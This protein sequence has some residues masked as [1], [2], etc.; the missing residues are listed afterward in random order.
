MIYFVLYLFIETV[1]SVSIAS[2]I[3]P[4]WTFIEIVATAAYGVWLLKNIH[5]QLFTTMQA[6]A[7]GEITQEEFEQMN[8]SMVLGAILL[9]IPGFFTD[10][11]GILLQFGVFS[12]FL[13]KKIFKLKAKEERD[14]VID[15]E[16]IER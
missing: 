14:D 11:L 1:V 5:I 4:I 3:G 15:V 16:I 9:I 13:A 10:I 6:L 12:K 7:N 8:L 2:R